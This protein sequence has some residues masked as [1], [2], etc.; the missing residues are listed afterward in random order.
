MA[1][2]Q[3][4][5]FP[6]H[7]VRKR[8]R[9]GGQIVQ[10]ASCRFP[11]PTAVIAVAV[12][13]NPS[14]VADCRLDDLVNILFDVIACFQC[15][16]IP[17]QF[18][19]DGGIED[20]IGVRNGGGRAQHPEFELVSGKGKGG[21]AVAVCGVAGDARQNVHADAQILLLTSAVAAVMLDGIQ[22]FHQLLAKVD[23]KNGGRR[24]IRAQAVV[25]AGA[26]DRNPE[27]CLI[28]VHCTDDGGQKQ[29]K[30]R[31]FKRRFARLKKVDSRVGAQRPVIV[32]AAA[33]DPGK[34]LFVEQADHPV[35]FGNAL[36]QLHHQLIVIRGNVGGGEQGRKLMLCR[37]R[38]VMF[39]FGGNP[40]FPELLVQ[41]LHIRLD[42]GFDT[43]EIVVVQLLPLGRARTEQGSAG[44]HQV[45]TPLVQRTVNQKILLLCT[46]RGAHRAHIAV[47]HKAQH[48]QRLLLQC[49]HGAQKRR[50]F[51][52][53]LPAV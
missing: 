43:A 21:G 19:G 11:H 50:L 52:Q 42:A 53:R 26:R 1:G 37:R 12:E 30:L 17:A 36:H 38:L 33:V 48:T 14:V 39:G 2:Q 41:L 49:L 29:Q 6:I 20:G 40:Q 45:G 4:H 25:I 31:V 47:S 18:L 28:I 8:V 5:V 32:F 7:Q 23:R 22:N 9:R 27:Q 44:I 10:S 35:L 24:F 16:R 13:Q 3:F 51:I 15:I 34:G 46:D